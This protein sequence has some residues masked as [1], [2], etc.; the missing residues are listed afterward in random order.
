MNGYHDHAHDHAHG[1]AGEIRPLNQPPE[2]EHHAG[3]AARGQ[4]GQGAGG[5]PSHHAHMVADFRRRFW[6]REVLD[7]AL[8]VREPNRGDR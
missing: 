1:Q 5:H 2:Q 6:V 4:S 7:L 3:H 8:V